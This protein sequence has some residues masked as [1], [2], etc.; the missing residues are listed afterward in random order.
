M[1]T[2]TYNIYEDNGGGLH[3]VV[4]IDHQP[5]DGITSLEYALA[6]EWLNIKDGLAAN[7]VVEIAGWEG[8][9]TPDELAEDYINDEESYTIVC[10][11]GELCPAVMG[12]AAMRY[13]GIHDNVV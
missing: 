10:K 5:V 2:A 13:F 7:P 6:G 4:Y 11:N 3:L 1:N 8:H 9:M 12:R